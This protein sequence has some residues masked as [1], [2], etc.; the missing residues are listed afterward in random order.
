MDA[1]LTLAADTGN[2]DRKMLLYFP[3]LKMSHLGPLPVEMAGDMVVI[4]GV[5]D[6]ILHVQP[7]FLTDSVDG[8]ET[9][10]D[11]FNFA[12]SHYPI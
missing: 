10:G 4:F 7:F 6:V 9:K 8:A 2:D 5:V 3:S 12:P 1:K 11:V